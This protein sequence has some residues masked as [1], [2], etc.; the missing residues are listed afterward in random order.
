MIK[1]SGG[2]IMNAGLTERADQQ[3]QLELKFFLLNCNTNQK[4]IDV[5][6][7]YLMCTVQF[8]NNNS[9]FFPIVGFER[10]V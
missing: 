10:N 3:Q 6:V 7:I 8:L 9:L 1:A 5:W 2:D 4:S